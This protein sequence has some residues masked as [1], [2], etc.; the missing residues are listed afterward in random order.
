MC[1]GGLD[2]CALSVRGVQVCADLE[3]CQL[4][5]CRLDCRVVPNLARQN[6]PTFNILYIYIFVF[7]VQKPF[8]LCGCWLFIDLL[9]WM[10]GLHFTIQTWK[11]C[12]LLIIIYSHTAKILSYPATWS[13]SQSW[14]HCDKSQN[15]LTFK[16]PWSIICCRLSRPWKRQI[17]FQNFQRLHR[18]PGLLDALRIESAFK[19]LY[20][21]NGTF[22]NR[23]PKFRFQFLFLVPTW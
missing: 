18:K 19:I 5:S 2:C 22:C 21:T 7:Q 9:W 16:V 11:Y 10:H 3:Q 8:Q 12:H 23:I 14:K 15:S 13:Q 4:M 17:C 1:E 6:S 20:K